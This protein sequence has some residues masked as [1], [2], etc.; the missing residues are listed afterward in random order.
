MHWSFS[1]LDDLPGLVWRALEEAAAAAEHPL[2]TAA[3]GTAT[4][5]D[6]SM[7]TV[8][9]RSVDTARRQLACHSD[10]RTAKV[11]HLRLNP[12]VQWLFHDAAARVQLRITA[13]AMTHHVDA[14]AEAAWKSVPVTNRPNYC[15]RHPPGTA[16]A[17]PEL[18]LPA[19]WR[20]R[21]PT[22]DET[23]RGFDNFAV[24]VTTVEHMD[25]LQLG[26]D[27]RHRRAG[28]T[29]TGTRFSG[30]WLAP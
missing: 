28:F 22:P 6:A 9:L 27:G 25:W 21:V 3:F 8:V 1:A 20:E 29:W 12:N 23:A 24:L 7:R 4:Q 19:E 15:S 10:V 18:A 26:A 13:L 5:F 17:A 14:I 11:Q 30:V 16:I 2:R